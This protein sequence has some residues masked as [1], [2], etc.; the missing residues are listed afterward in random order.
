[1]DIDFV[2]KQNILWLLLP[3]REI[4]KLSFILKTNEKKTI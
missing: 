3:F 1:M 2:N 4:K